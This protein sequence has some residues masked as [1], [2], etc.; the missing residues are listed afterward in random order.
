MLDISLHIGLITSLSVGR[1][2]ACGPIHATSEGE[3]GGD[4]DDVGGLN[5]RCEQLKVAI[6]AR[7][8]PQTLRDWLRNPSYLT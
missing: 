4:R 7:D 6:T 3:G 1:H 8:P 2:P 5:W